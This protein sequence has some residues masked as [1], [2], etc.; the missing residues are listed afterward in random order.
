MSNDRWKALGAAIAKAGLPILGGAVAGPAGATLGAAI[1]GAI[2]GDPADPD[3]LAAIIQANPEAAVRLRE[4]EANAAIEIQRLISAQAQAETQ[5]Q[6]QDIAQ[7]NET[8]RAEYQAGDN[9]RGRWRPFFG[10]IVA[11]SWAVQMGGTT[12]IAFYA[13]IESPTYAAVTIK[14]LGEYAAGTAIMWSMA[15][16]VLGVAIKQRSNDKARAMGIPPES[17]L[18]RLFNRSEGNG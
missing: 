13:A 11:I 15:L 18:G 1:A 6:A 2:G 5:A 10:Y 14:A 3:Q 9:F 7:V 16:A 17:L 12:A 8:M 4:V